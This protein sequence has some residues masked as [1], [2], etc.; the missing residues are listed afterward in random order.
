M[1]KSKHLYEWR[2]E[3]LSILEIKF[4]TISYIVGQQHAA[5]N[6]SVFLPGKTGRGGQMKTVGSCS[7]DV[8]DSKNDFG[9]SAPP[10]EK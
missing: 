10:G 8:L 5:L 4:W 6:S 1:Y 9:V 3:D 7:I 2:Y